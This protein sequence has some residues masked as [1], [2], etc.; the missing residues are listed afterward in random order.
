MKKFAAY[1]LFFFALGFHSA[2]A[3]SSCD[4]AAY[5]C[6]VA[7]NCPSGY[8]ASCSCTAQGCSG[9]CV[10]AN[11]ELPEMLFENGGQKLIDMVVRSD[12]KGIGDVF[13]KNLGREVVFIK[14]SEVKKLV[15]GKPLFKSYWDVAEF[16][17]GKGKLTINK[18]PFEIWKGKRDTLLK[19]GEYNICAR[20]VPAQ[21]ILDEIN[22]L[23]GRNF[24]IVGGDPKSRATAVIRGYSLKEVRDSLS[25]TRNIIISED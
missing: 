6:S 3:Q 10:K 16:L 21:M 12:E 22:F 14:A 15:S 20:D 2:Q 5:G 7:Q 1:L 23:T 11:S 25:S 8:V 9:Q 13:S 19:G 24:K 18:L 4:C 17:A